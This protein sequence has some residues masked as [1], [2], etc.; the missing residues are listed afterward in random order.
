LGGMTWDIKMVAIPT[1]EKTPIMLSSHTYW[2][3]DG[4]S[5][6]ETKLVLN[7]T[8][9]MP[10]GGERVEV[11]SILIPTGNILANQAGSVNDFWSAPK[12]I[13]SSFSSPEI[14]GN[15]GFNCSG[16][17]KNLSKR[18]LIRQLSES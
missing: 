4:F 1:T 5:N 12:Q 2:N 18:L 9:Y 7:H 3:L 16:Y 13:G 8:F 15:C 17:G 10:Y 6:D 14:K 11:D